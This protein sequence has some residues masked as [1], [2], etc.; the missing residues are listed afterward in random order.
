MVCDYERAWLQLGR[1][2]ADK[3]QHGRAELLTA[4]AEIADDCQVTGGELA[5]MLRLYG[6]E[7]ER[8][9]SIEA[10]TH[11]REPGDFDG[12]LVSPADPELAGH[13]RPEGG[14]DGSSSGAGA[15]HLNGRRR[16]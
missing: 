6:V 2:I 10:E 8:A 16:V 13:H 4:M 1:R 7:V 3:T 9:R 12:G 11:R 14:H 15:G 5:R